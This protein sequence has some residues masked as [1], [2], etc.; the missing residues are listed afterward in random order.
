MHSVGSVQSTR[1]VDQEQPTHVG[2]LHVGQ[3]D[4]PS[5]ERDDHDLDVQGI[6]LLVVLSQLRK[7]LAARQSPQMPVKHQQQPVFGVVLKP[8]HRT[9]GIFQLKT[10]RLFA[11]FAGH[12]SRSHIFT[13]PF[14]S[15][16]C[17]RYFGIMRGL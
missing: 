2:F 1:L 10:D 6:D 5:L 4:W 9:I 16:G 14:R 12:A 17:S 15:S 13:Y 3:G 8:M 7:M 11:N